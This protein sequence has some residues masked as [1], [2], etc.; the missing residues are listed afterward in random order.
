MNRVWHRLTPWP[1]SVAGL[2]RLRSRFVVA[3]LSNGNVSLLVDMAK[4]AGLPWD[5]ILSAEIFHRY[6][7]D[8]EVYRQAAD[9]LGFNLSVAVSDRLHDVLPRVIVATIMLA[10]GLVLAVMLGGVTRRLFEGTG[11]RGSRFRGQIVTAVLSVFAVLIALEQLGL[12]AQFIIS[13]VVILLASVGIALGLAFGL[14]CRDLARDF[15]V[16]YLRSLDREGP[17][18]PS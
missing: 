11:L 6:K 17:Q 9:M 3:T 15:V 16:E 18:R 8:L 12:A 7:P 10:F 5:C 2:Q 13:I 4:H 1:D 14:G